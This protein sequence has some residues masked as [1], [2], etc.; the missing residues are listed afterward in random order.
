MFKWLYNRFVRFSILV[1]AFFAGNN[2]FHKGIYQGNLK[3]FFYP[4]LNCY[5]CPL[6]RFSC[7]M[8]TYQHFIA[9]GSFP[10]Y[11]VG[12]ISIIGVSLGRII[13]GWVC[14]FGF[15]QEILYKIK[16]F[17]F[18]VSSK[19]AY[20]KYIMLFVVA[21]VIVFITGENWFCKLC[22][23]GGVMAGIPHLSLQAALRPLIGGLFYLKY[24]IVIF[25]ITASVFIKRPFC[26]FG[27][28]LG[29]LFGLF[30]K[31]TFFQIK[32]DKEKCTECY[33]CQNV[34]PMDVEIFKYPDSF[35]CIRCARC[36]KACPQDALAFYYG[37]I[38]K[39]ATLPIKNEKSI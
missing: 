22:P 14:P 39:T 12:F 8:G 11:V 30:N 2:Y 19:H 6:A 23:S 18:R 7:P 31:F 25:V 34:C 5:A 17:K 27:C 4:G 1:G 3:N 9:N 20:T 37:P 36:I 29:A 16:T 38:A 32:V 24:S 15:L 13:C 33:I 28:A 10:F 21:T 35:D 26:R